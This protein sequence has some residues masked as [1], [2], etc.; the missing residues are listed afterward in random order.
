MNW[1]AVGVETGKTYATGT[2]ADCVRVINERISNHDWGREGTRSD[3]TIT[4]KEAIRVMPENK[5]IVN[6]DEEKEIELLRIHFRE[7]E[8]AEKA[9]AAA[10]RTERERKRKAERETRRIL[11]MK[12]REEQREADRDAKRIEKEREKAERMALAEQLKA[13][14]KERAERAKEKLARMPRIVSDNPKSMKW[15]EEE[16]NFLLENHEMDLY[17]LLELMRAYR[18]KLTINALTTRLHVVRKKNGIKSARKYTHW[19]PEMDAYI[20]ENYRSMESC[21]MA[22]VF[23]VTRTSLYQRIIKLRNEGHELERAK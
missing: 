19:T 4:H 17:D 22:V 12:V 21:D 3:A 1:K 10:A 13:K 14:Q 18:P 15:T 23:G 5:Q 6:P 2:H 20:L 16:E 8:A 9:Q 11:E 7:S